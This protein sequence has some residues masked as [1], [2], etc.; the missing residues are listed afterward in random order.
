MHVYVYLYINAFRTDAAEDLLP[1]HGVA[2][3]VGVPQLRQTGRELRNMEP[4]LVSRPS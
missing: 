2:P 1:Q 4:R 3:A